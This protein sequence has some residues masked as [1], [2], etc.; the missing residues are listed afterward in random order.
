MAGER[1]LGAQMLSLLGMLDIDVSSPVLLGTAAVLGG[2]LTVGVGNLRDLWQRR[3]LRRDVERFEV[4]Y[5]S[6]QWSLDRLEFESDESE[7]L[8]ISHSRSGFPLHILEAAPEPRFA[9][10]VLTDL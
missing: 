7:D 10:V 9:N 1:Y 8:A 6:D 4:K 5:E 2:V 3:R